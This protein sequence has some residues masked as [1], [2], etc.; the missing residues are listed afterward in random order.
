[1]WWDAVYYITVARSLLAGDGLVGLGGVPL[2]TQPP[3]YPALLAGGGGLFGIDPYAVAGPLNAVIFGLTV[4]VAGWWLRRRLHSRFLWLWGCF[5]IALALPLADM[6]SHALSESA[7]ILFVTL[8]LTQ[9]DAHLD[10]GGRASLMRAAAFSAA[11]CLTRYMGASMILAV[12]P[13]AACSA[14][15]AAG[16]D[17]AH[18]RLYAA[19][20]GAGGSVDAAELSACRIHDRRKRLGFLLLALHRGRGVAH[21]RRG[22]VARRLDRPG[23]IGAR[24]GRRPCVPSPLAAEK[25]RSRRCAGCPG[26]VARVRRFCACVPDAARRR[27]DVRRHLGWIAGE[28][29]RS[30]VCSAAVCG[31]AAAG[32]RPAVCAEAFRAGG[33]FKRSGEDSCSRADV[34]AVA[35]GGRAGGAAWTRDTVLE[36][37]RATRVRRAAVEGFGERAVHSRGGSDRRDPEQCPPRPEFAR[38]RSA[39]RYELLCEPD[40]LR[41]ALSNALGGGDVHV[42]YFYFSDWGYQRPCPRQQD[43]DLRSALSREPWL[44][45]VRNRRTASC[46]V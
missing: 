16:E 40:H 23:P 17:E 18:R 41:W 42:L 27:D 33:E 24:G 26:S 5:S 44:E 31:V 21:R 10:G 45:L 36:C 1:M 14:S 39:R 13:A 6:A 9:I 8:S 2:T 3:M 11:A 7:F 29:P 22:L 25:R 38:R 32:R 37:R 46:I 4:L 35:A 28:I 19:C 20:R 30:R 15:C 43:D 34:G 12:V